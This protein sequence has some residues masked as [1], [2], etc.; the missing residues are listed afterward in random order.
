M[1]MSR[2]QLGI[3]SASRYVFRLKQCP[4]LSGF[5]ALSTG[6]QW[7]AYDSTDA[8]NHI[9]VTASMAVLAVRNHLSTRKILRYS[10]STLIFAAVK[11]NNESNPAAYDA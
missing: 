5:Q 6:V 10:N 9:M 3:S 7:N 8:R 2:I 1:T 11:V 4:S